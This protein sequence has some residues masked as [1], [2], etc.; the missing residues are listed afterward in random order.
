MHF[1]QPVLDK[2]RLIRFTAFHL[3][4]P[5]SGVRCSCSAIL[6][7]G[8]PHRPM[9]KYVHC[10]LLSRG[11]SYGTCQELTPWLDAKFVSLHTCTRLKMCIRCDLVG[12]VNRCFECHAVTGQAGSTRSQSTATSTSSM[13]SDRHMRGGRSSKSQPASSPSDVLDSRYVG[14]VCGMMRVG[15][16]GS[17]QRWGITFCLTTSRWP[18]SMS[19]AQSRHVQIV[20][21]MIPNDVK[22]YRGLGSGLCTTRLLFVLRKAS[23]HRPR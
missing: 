8:S 21:R 11:I 7:H 3:A 4:T 12:L 18:L 15:R 22:M 1:G 13:R 23:G 10:A 6:W 9:S 19:T 5:T 16:C 14:G 2:I 20:Y 17:S